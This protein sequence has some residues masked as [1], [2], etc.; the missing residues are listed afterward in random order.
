MQTPPPSQIMQ[1]TI[2][3][4]NDP[5]LSHTPV[6]TRIG[7]NAITV[8]EFL[9]DYAAMEEMRCKSVQKRLGGTL[10]NAVEIYARL[11]TSETEDEVGQGPKKYPNHPTWMQWI[12]NDTNW[13]PKK[14]SKINPNWSKMKNY[15]E[16]WEKMRKIAEVT[17]RRLPQFGNTCVSPLATHPK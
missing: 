5:C 1:L 10:K 17:L 12:Q 16:L 7:N 14:R 11:D 6:K 8:F 3:P 2:C 4:D 9:Q 15:A 13:P